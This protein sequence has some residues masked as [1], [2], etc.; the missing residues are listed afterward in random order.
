MP[1]QRISQTQ[2]GEAATPVPT[3]R[4]VG[5][6]KA[7]KLEREW[8]CG[9]TCSHRDARNSERF[10]VRMRWQGKGLPR[11]K[12]DRREDTMWGERSAMRRAEVSSQKAQAE[13][14]QRDRSE[15]TL[16]VHVWASAPVRRR[17]TK[18][19]S[20]RLE[21]RP[22]LPR[23][24]V[25][26]TGPGGVSGA[27]GGSGLGP[28]EAPSGGDSLGEATGDLARGGKMFRQ[29]WLRR[30]RA[31]R[32][33]WVCVDGVGAG[34]EV[35]RAGGE[36]DGPGLGR[37]RGR[38]LRII[39]GRKSECRQRRRRA[40]LPEVH[41]LRHGRRVPG[42]AVHREFMEKPRGRRV[43]AGGVGVRSPGRRPKQ[44]RDLTQRRRGRAG[45][46][47]RVMQIRPARNQ[48]CR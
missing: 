21:E 31:R 8:N 3:D 27:G 5:R 32:D 19:T 1:R 29:R 24:G 10:V 26:V 39:P 13:A 14:D 47:T 38:R 4:H 33:R 44:Q 20:R 43:G 37:G 36:T 17:E 2:T 25:G 45:L 22:A 18:D 41:T 34:G 9:S 7:G 30:R 42:V 12:M 48:P 35:G 15:P 46:V 6:P 40:W 23:I 28:G 16:S 11:T